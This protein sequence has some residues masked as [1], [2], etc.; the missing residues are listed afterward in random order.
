MAVE[1]REKMNRNEEV[2]SAIKALDGLWSAYCSM[3]EKVSRWYMK[4]MDYEQLEY[5]GL[6]QERVKGEFPNE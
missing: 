1:R 5:M 3:V 2:E 4:D 6:H